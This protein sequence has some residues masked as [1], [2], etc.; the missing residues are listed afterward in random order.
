MLKCLSELGLERFN[1]G[2]LLHVLNEQSESGELDAS[3]LR[4]SMDRWWRHCVR[5]EEE[6]IWIGRVIERVR[7]A[8]GWVFTREMYEGALRRRK[9]TGSFGP[10]ESE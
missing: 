1:A 4:R 3:T 10:M 2:F 7:R 6:R 8:D 9:E 5:D